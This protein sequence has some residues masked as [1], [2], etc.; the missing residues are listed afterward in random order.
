MWFFK[1]RVPVEEFTTN[2]IARSLPR[3][4]KFFAEENQRAAQPINLNEAL[5]KEA[6]AGMC[7]FF[8]AGHFPDTIKANTELMQRAYKAVRRALTKL[9]AN[10][11]QAH[12]WW[13]A[14]NDGQILHGNDQPLKV[15]CKVVWDRSLPNRP[16]QEQSALHALGYFLQMD[17]ESVTKVKLS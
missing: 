16:F 8:L 13:K 4:I 9:N 15:A 11:D 1:K 3:A 5:L 7:L 6:G 12:Y 10:A 17:V 2:L 14:F